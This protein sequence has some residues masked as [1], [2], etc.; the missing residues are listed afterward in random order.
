MRADFIGIWW[1]VSLL[2][3]ENVIHFDTD[4]ADMWL[5]VTHSTFWGVTL[6]KMYNC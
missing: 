5:F 2:E 6:E 3:N 4:G 1:N